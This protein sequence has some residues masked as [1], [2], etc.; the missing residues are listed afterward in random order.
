M[1][2]G[3]SATISKKGRDT[4]FGGAKIVASIRGTNGIVPVI[5]AVVAPK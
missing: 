3:T 2:D 5:D 4:Y 1:A